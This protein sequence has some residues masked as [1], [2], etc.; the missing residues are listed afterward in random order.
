MEPHPFIYIKP[1]STITTAISVRTVHV[2]K[3][4]YTTDLNQRTQEQ[5]AA[6]QTW[7][8]EGS[9]VQPSAGRRLRLGAKEHLSGQLA[10]PT[11]DQLWLLSGSS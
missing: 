10:S 4:S 9:D 3:S 8:L 6:A 1:I 7:R 11:C 2:A 5:S